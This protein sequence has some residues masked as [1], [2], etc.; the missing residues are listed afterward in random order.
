MKALEYKSAF[1]S[2]AGRPVFHHKAS[3]IAL[4]ECAKVVFLA[5]PGVLFVDCVDCVDCV[6]MPNTS[7]DLDCIS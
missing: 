3:S 2:T 6:E 7:V 4:W 1:L 5:V